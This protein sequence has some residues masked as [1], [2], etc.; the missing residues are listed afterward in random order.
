MYW[1]RTRPSKPTFVSTVMGKHSRYGVHAAPRT[2]TQQGIANP[3]PN[4]DPR[5]A[6]PRRSLAVDIEPA[7]RCVSCHRSRSTNGR[8]PHPV[9]E[10]RL[11]STARQRCPPTKLRSGRTLMGVG[12]GARCNAFNGRSF[13][14]TSPIRGGGGRHATATILA[15][16]DSDCLR[17]PIAN[18]GDAC[19]SAMHRYS[20]MKRSHP[21]RR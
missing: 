19:R 12:D 6:A 4:I 18:R 1:R 21:V 17:A 9:S 20:N 15:V 16:G 10:R 7:T 11:R 13:R 5:V 14:L 2:Y 3:I 8:I